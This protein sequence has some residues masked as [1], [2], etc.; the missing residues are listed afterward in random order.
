MATHIANGKCSAPNRPIVKQTIYQRH[1]PTAKYLLMA[2]NNRMNTN[3]KFIT[4]VKDLDYKQSIKTTIS[5]RRFKVVNPQS[6][7]RLS[8]NTSLHSSNTRPIRKI[9]GTSTR[10]SKNRIP[11][12]QFNVIV[13]P[14]NEL[15][16]YFHWH[17]PTENY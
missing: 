16:N 15:R 6:T 8:P 13:L 4:S 17:I 11:I 1:K 7:K 5:I 10:Q 14:T 9:I 3:G 2:Q 12:S